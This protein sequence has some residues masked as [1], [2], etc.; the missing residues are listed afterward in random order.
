VSSTTDSFPYQVRRADDLP[1]PLRAAWNS[2]KDLRCQYSVFAPPLTIV[3]RRHIQPPAGNLIM[4][5]DERLLVAID[6][7]AGRVKTV[8]IHFDDLI[9]VEL[10]QDLLFSWMKL[11]FGRSALNQIKI[12]F[13]TVGTELIKPVLKFI[14]RRLD[15]RLREAIVCAKQ[16]LPLPFK[17]ANQLNACLVPGEQTVSVAFQPE[18]RKRGFLLNRQIAPPM[19]VALTDRQLLLL[20]EEPAGVFEKLGRY[21]KIYTY[22]PRSRVDFVDVVRRSGSVPLAVFRLT[23]RNENISFPIEAIVSAELAS[24]FDSF[25]DSV[26]SGIGSR[27][28]NV[29]VD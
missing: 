10:G 1:G 16:P 25:C 13:N 7:G 5:F 11:V 26:R 4:I 22:C 15:N 17:F 8:E 3:P 27:S 20:T 19:L 23:L 6:N 21:T 14:R 18:I 24:E 29:Q 9:F 2:P 28:R 12:P